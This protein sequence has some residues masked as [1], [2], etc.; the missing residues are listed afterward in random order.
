[1]T[2]NIYLNFDAT[3]GLYGTFVSPIITCT[4]QE[5]ISNSYKLTIAGNEYELN[6]GDKSLEGCDYTEC[7]KSNSI[8][9]SSDTTIKL[10]MREGDIDSANDDYITAMFVKNVEFDKEGAKFN[11]KPTR[12]KDLDWE[13]DNISSIHL[14]NSDKIQVCF[15][16]D[17]NQS[18]IDVNIHP[19]KLTLK[20]I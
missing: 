12:Y 6:S 14:K 8:K 9:V 13:V 3:V 4:L 20:S 15:I 16:M 7:K 11:I 2:N 17:S 18:W 5:F 10:V 19:L 1:M